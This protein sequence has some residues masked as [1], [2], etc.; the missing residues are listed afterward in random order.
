MPGQ[1]K[2]KRKINMIKM[3]KTVRS[4]S[5][6]F[7]KY[8]IL[9]CGIVKT[10]LLAKYFTLK[11]GHALQILSCHRTKVKRHFFKRPLWKLTAEFESN[12]KHL[13]L[14]PP[15]NKRRYFLSCHLA[16]PTET[17]AKTRH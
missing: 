13:K 1:S 9:F 11:V 4:S 14:K 8:S 6:S 7:L 5:I 17:K 2:W 15:L 16:L 10:Y 12:L 3:Y